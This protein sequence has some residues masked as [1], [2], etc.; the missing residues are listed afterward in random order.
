MIDHKIDFI[1]AVR[2][3]LIVSVQA[4]A[5][6]PLDDPHILTAMAQA[7]VRGGAAAIRACQPA[8]IAAIRAAVG[9][10][11]IGLSKKEYRDSSVYITPTLADA[12]AVAATGCAVIALDAT[13]RPRP[14]GETLG[15]IV[16]GLRQATSA[17]LMADVATVQEGAA[18][19]ELGFEIISSTLSGYTAESSGSDPCQPD[20]ELVAALVREAGGRAAVIAEGRI[21]HPEE[22][23]RLLALGA[24]AVVGGT[25]ITRPGAITRRFIEMMQPR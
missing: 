5:G 9:V 15:T 13:L 20:Y 22:A 6:D 4:D 23:Q 19:L 2:G 1:A 16:A 7:V 18:A 10:P 3:R 25:A 11:L 14:G 24:H 12:L 21:W 8:N 17:L